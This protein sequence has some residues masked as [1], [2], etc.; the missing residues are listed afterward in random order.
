MPVTEGIGTDERLDKFLFGFFTAAIF[1]TAGALGFEIGPAVDTSQ[2]NLTFLGVMGAGLVAAA[3][4]R[5][6]LDY[7]LTSWQ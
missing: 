1:V 7:E 3:I 5:R 4:A 2:L 6:R